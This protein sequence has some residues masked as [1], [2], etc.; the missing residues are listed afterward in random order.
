M[1]EESLKSKFPKKRNKEYLHE[2]GL[3]TM[4]ELFPNHG[5]PQDDLLYGFLSLIYD[6]VHNILDLKQKMKKFFISTMR[7]NYISFNNVEEYIE[8]A[9]SKDFIIKK[10]NNDVEL[11]KKGK[12]YVESCYIAIQHESFWM[13]KLLSEKVVLALTAVFL[14]ILSLLKILVG[15]QLNSQGMINDGF[16]NFTDLIKV[17]IIFIIGINLKKDR[18][19]SIIIISMMLFTGVSLIISSIEAILFPSIIIPTIQAYILVNQTALLAH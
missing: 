14:I 17:A 11:T 16:E 4:K 19:A 2:R 15:F 3:K 6:G 5:G 7:Q 8:I 10:A 13:K 1:L 12:I 9:L 18:L